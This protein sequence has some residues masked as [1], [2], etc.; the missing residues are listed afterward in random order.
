MFVWLVLDDQLATVM[1]EHALFHCKSTSVSN[2]AHVGLK[3]PLA[4]IVVANIQSLHIELVNHSLHHLTTIA[5]HS[6]AVVSFLSLCSSSSYYYKKRSIDKIALTLC[7]RFALTN[8]LKQHDA[9]SIVTPHTL[10]AVHKYSH[11]Y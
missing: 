10:L 5:I 4:A 6:V 7:S 2:I 1:Q 8:H 11:H 3:F 9:Y